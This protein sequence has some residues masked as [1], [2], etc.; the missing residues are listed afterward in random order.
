MKNKTDK[1]ARSNEKKNETLRWIWN[2]TQPY[3][4][5]SY[6]L[7]ALAS[8]NTVISL[9]N[10]VLMRTLIDA[11]VGRDEKTL[12]QT[13]VIMLTLTVL[14][15]GLGIL[16]QYLRETASVRIIQHIQNRFFGILLR[17]NYTAVSEKHSEE[18]MNRFIL[19]VSGV[20]SVFTSMLPGVASAVIHFTVAG[21]LLLRISPVFLLAAAVG[22]LGMALLNYGLK[23]PFKRR[24]RALRETTGRKNTYLSEHLSK[25]IIVKA[26]NREERIEQ[27]AGEQTEAVAQ[28]KID[29]LRLS[30][31]KNSI[32]RFATLFAYLAVLFYCAYKIFRGEIS[33][34]ASVM[35]MRLMSQISTPLSELSGYLTR[36][37]E[38]VVN[39]ERLQEAERFPD[40]FA[41]SI[42]DDVA[43]QKFYHEEFRDIAFSDVTF[44]YRSADGEE[45]GSLPTVFSHVDICIPKH[46]C[47]AFTGITGSGKSTIFKLLMSFYP[48]QSGTKTVHTADGGE[49]PLDASFRRLF[50]YVPQGNQLMAGTI[51]EMVT[52]GSKEDLYRDQEIWDVLETACAK[53]FIEKLPQ[54]LDTAIQEKGVG[55]SEGQLQRIAVARALFTQRPILLLDEATSALDEATEKKLLQHL[56]SMTDRTILFVTHRP[57]GLAICD[58][59]VHIDGNRV[60]TRM[61]EH[62]GKGFED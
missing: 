52:F 6:V 23:E 2:A 59:E 19:D 55:L 36:Y 12:I 30:L 50:A 39:A 14:Q 18:W 54:G 9:A 22:G 4:G 58:R 16:R 28:R 46:S 60:T 32:Q 40:D 31:M 27:N 3:H 37:F 44:S 56:K 8:V 5:R 53:D 21:F 11:A 61:L 48:L 62:G 45:K 26:F 24:Q 34:G 33:Y 1:N 41:G 10:V 7:I 38:V 15:F 29:V 43:I 57:N 35:F 42:R 49:L 47:V 17:K 25:L 51:R 20:A 13:G